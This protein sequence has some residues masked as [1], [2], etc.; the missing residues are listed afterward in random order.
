MFLVFILVHVLLFG[1]FVR[2][3]RTDFD[4]ELPEA[5]ESS[6]T[7]DLYNDNNNDNT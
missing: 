7:N 3:N 2:E 4:Y 6:S 5:Q 1:W